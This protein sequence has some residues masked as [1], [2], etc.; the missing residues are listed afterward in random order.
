MEVADPPTQVIQGWVARTDDIQAKAPPKRPPI[1]LEARPSG[2]V[3]DRFGRIREYALDVQVVRA[4][5]AQRLDGDIDGQRAKT[6]AVQLRAIEPVAGQASQF[7]RI[8]VQPE[9]ELHVRP[10]GVVVPPQVDLD[11]VARGDKQ[12][13]VEPVAERGVPVTQAKYSR[14]WLRGVF[15]RVG[16]LGLVPKHMRQILF[17]AHDFQ[18]RDLP[19]NCK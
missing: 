19:A 12:A 16:E 2:I 10:G 15:L 7:D 6:C 3:E 11:A 17:A 9:H 18:C 5:F 14:R 8:A 1:R 4:D 13:R